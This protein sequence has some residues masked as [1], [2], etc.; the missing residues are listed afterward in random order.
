MEHAGH[1]CMEAIFR[2][3]G[4]TCGKRAFIF[5]GRGNNGGDGYVIARLLLQSGWQVRVCILAER[6]R[7]EGDAAINLEQLP[8]SVISYCTAPDNRRIGIRRRSAWPTSSWTP[9]WGPV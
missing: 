2:E 6:D 1:A 5:A 4:L 7:I 9:C 3:F 8:R